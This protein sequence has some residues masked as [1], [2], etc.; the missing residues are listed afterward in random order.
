MARQEQIARSISTNPNGFMK[1]VKHIGLYV[2]M[3]TS[4]FIK[5]MFRENEWQVNEPFDMF[6]FRAAF[7]TDRE[8]V[9]ILQ[10]VGKFERN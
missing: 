10:A 8:T 1:L 6:P 3:A 4:D 7:T 2:P 9:I 5:S